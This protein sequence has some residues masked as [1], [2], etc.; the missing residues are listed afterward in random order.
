[1]GYDKNVEEKTYTDDLFWEIINSRKRWSFLNLLVSLFLLLTIQLFHLDRWD[2]VYLVYALWQFFVYGKLLHSELKSPGLSMLSLFFMGALMTLALPSYSY[3]VGM[4][5]HKQFYC[6]DV[7]EITD[8]LF[9]TSAAMNVYYS[10]FIL[11]LTWFTNERMFIVD[12]NVIA[13]KYNLFYLALFLYLVA[14]V[15]R[16]VPFLGSISSTLEQFASSLPLLV[17]FLLAIYCGLSSTRDK[18]YWL[19]L[20][21]L[22]IEIVGAFVFGMYK[23]T[24]IINA[25]MYILYYY[26]HTRT[27]GRKIINTSS[28]VIS[29]FFLIFITYIVYPFIMIKRNESGFQLNSDDDEMK[30]VDNMDVFMRVLTL[31]YD[32]SEIGGGD[33]DNSSA[34]TG[35][36]SAIYANAFFYQD[37]YHNGYHSDLLKMSSQSLIPRFL[38]P[39]KLEGSEGN[40]TFSYMMGKEFNPLDTSSNFVGLFAGSYFWG[41]W[42]GSLLMCIINAWILS[43]LL[44]TCFSHLDNLLAW[45]VLTMIL[46]PM[47]RCFEES[48]DGGVKSDVFFL[49]YTVL[50]QCFSIFLVWW[51]KMKQDHH[52]E[53]LLS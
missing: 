11:L 9:R 34:F 29:L 7:Y 31:D 23:G 33:D 51:R 30:E 40:M 16:V 52:E 1:M 24:I 19:F 3:A 45:I 13:K 18:Y 14:I 42:L 4:I 35:R 8:F 15:F 28:I 53:A 22:V 27:M 5:G 46:I 6:L 32:F 26:L 39:D 25:A 43:L 49:I 36:M 20:A 47:M 2:W 12:I 37:A 50:V 10:L 48:S 41:G 44:K 17:V 21:V 38:Y